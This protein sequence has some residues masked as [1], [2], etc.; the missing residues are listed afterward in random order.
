MSR[1]VSVASKI[2][3]YWAGI[4]DFGDSSLFLNFVEYPIVADSPA[5]L[6]SGS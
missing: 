1:I 6:Q 4:V 5:L 2:V 3:D